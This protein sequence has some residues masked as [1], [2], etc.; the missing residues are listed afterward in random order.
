LRQDVGRIG[1]IEETV[2]NQPTIRWSGDT[3]VILSGIPSLVVRRH[4]VD[5]IAPFPKPQ[6]FKSNQ[7]HQCV[8]RASG[9]P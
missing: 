4:E 6:T 3:A 7:L 5:A 9:A 1:A 8:M 2:I